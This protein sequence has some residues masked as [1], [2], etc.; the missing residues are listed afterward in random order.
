M[1]FPVLRSTNN[2]LDNSFNDFFNDGWLAKARATAPSVNVK[3]NEHEYEVEVAA[4]GM[5]KDDFLL[6]RFQHTLQCFF[7]ILNQAINNI[8]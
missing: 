2:W 5:T 1:L 6:L 7:D 3:E 8:I 4:P